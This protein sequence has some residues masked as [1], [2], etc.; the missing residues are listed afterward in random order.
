MN[1]SENKI[2]RTF[3]VRAY[4]INKGKNT[5]YSIFATIKKEDAEKHILREKDAVLLEINEKIFPAVIRKLKTGKRF[6]LG[7]TIPLRLKDNVPVQQDF[8]IKIIGVNH[9]DKDKSNVKG[10]VNLEKIIPEKSIHNFS[11][12][13]FRKG[14]NS[15]IFWICSKGNKP[16]K[17]PKYIPI[18][19]LLEFSG[20]FFCEGF[21]ARKNHK[22]RDRFSFSNADIEQIEYFVNICKTTFKIPILEW[23]AQILYNENKIE[24][25]SLLNYWS[26]LGFK[27]DKISFVKNNSVNSYFGICIL[28]IYNSTLAEVIYHINEE[29]ARLALSSK[30]NA[31]SFFR[32]LSRGDL[33]I[34]KNSNYVG[35]TTE[36]EEN[37]R[38]FV[39][40]CKKIGVTTGKYWHDTRGNKKGSWNVQICG[41]S[42]FIKL[43]KLNC[44]AHS[45]RRNALFYNILKNN[46][47]KEYSYLLLVSKGLKT[48]KEIADKMSLSQDTTRH[49]LRRYAKEGLLER[50]YKNSKNL[51]EA[52]YSLTKKG[53]N[54][55]RFFDNMVKSE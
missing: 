31:I 6:M 51:Q 50:H 41:Y 29:C 9:I 17:L 40:L 8:K 23:N 33:G 52:F 7:F 27:K 54:E 37:I 28:N 25:S 3:N 47:Q 44:I 32:G 16:V 49:F 18:I 2:P 21:K 39:K 48:S 45:K 46:K 55:L 13:M 10:A 36:S 30:K 53:I 43:V 26:R 34:G 42:D 22:H 1:N 11:I 24:I 20:A 19:P 38:F 15:R 14:K 12:Y 35:F 4:V 5:Q